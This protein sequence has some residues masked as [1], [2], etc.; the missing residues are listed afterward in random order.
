MC[1]HSSVALLLL[2]Q[3]NVLTLPSNDLMIASVVIDETPLLVFQN[4]GRLPSEALPE[5]EW[6][7][8][9]NYSGGL[10]HF[11]I[12]IYKSPVMNSSNLIYTRQST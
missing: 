11:K 9:A 7:T 6:L 4:V 8:P 1:H 2:I 5:F 10:L 3:G 12:E